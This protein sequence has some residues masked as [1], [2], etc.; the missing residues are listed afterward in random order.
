MK[1]ATDRSISIHYIID[2]SAGKSF[3]LSEGSISGETYAQLYQQAQ[4][5]MRDDSFFGRWHF[6]ITWAKAPSLSG[7]ASLPL[8]G[9]VTF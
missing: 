7:P 6:A 2:N 3:L 5:E 8:N 4:I 9:T 1:H